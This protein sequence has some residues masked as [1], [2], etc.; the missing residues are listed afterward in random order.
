MDLFNFKVFSEWSCPHLTA[1]QEASI[2]QYQYVKE[3]ANGIGQF[4][5]K[6]TSVVFYTNK[7]ISLFLHANAIA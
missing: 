2:F 5:R 7:H 6:I 1:P 3:L 4:G